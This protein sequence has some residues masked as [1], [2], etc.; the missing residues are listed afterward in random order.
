MRYEFPVHDKLK[1]TLTGFV[2]NVTNNTIYDGFTSS[3]TIGSFIDFAIPSV[4]R[5]WGASLAADF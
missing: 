5:T 3:N 2:K 1:M 4:G